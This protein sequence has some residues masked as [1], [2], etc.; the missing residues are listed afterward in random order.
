VTNVI[1]YIP[2]GL[3]ITQI[4]ANK[5]PKSTA[6]KLFAVICGKSEFTVKAASPAYRS[7]E[8]YENSVYPVLLSVA[9]H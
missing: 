3:E 2:I 8:L 4:T 5:S 1:K 7:L 9:E 6:N